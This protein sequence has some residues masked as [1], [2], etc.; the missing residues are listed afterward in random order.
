MNSLGNGYGESRESRDTNIGDVLAAHLFGF[1]SMTLCPTS[2]I[3]YCL[4][5]TLL[6]VLQK[7]NDR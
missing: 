7:Y 5:A 1:N 3:T 4:L 6:N 2:H